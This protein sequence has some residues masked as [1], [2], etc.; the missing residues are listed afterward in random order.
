M[1]ET[2]AHAR[3]S[4]CDTTRFP[5]G[6]RFKQ[7]KQKKGFDV[8]GLWTLKYLFVQ[9]A[10]CFHGNSAL[11]YSSQS[12]HELKRTA[13]KQSARLSAGKKKTSDAT[14]AT[15]SSSG[16]H[17]I[18]RRQRVR[19]ARPKTGKDSQRHKLPGVAPQRVCC[20]GETDT[21]IPPIA[22]WKPRDAERQRNLL[23]DRGRDRERVSDRE[24]ERNDNRT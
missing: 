11:S 15:Q 14:D 21:L 1:D 6:E 7:N 4:C 5:P 12:V 19:H 17:A 20:L 16:T 22:Y 3:G 13:L 8:K 24:R 2:E 18:F 9:G 23:G 10:L